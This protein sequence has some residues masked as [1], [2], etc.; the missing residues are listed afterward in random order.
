VT[1]RIWGFD[2]LCP[3][4]I[5]HIPGMRKLPVALFRRT[6]SVL[7]KSPN[8]RHS[9]GHPASGRGTLRPIVTKREAGSDGRVCAPRRSA[10][11]ADGEAVWSWPPDAE[12]KLRKTSFA[13]RRWLQSPAHRGDH[14]VSRKPSRRECRNVRRTLGFELVCFLHCTRGRGCDAHP[15]FPAPS[16]LARAKIMHDSDAIAPR[17]R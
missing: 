2:H 12:V 3:T 13:R 1:L 5:S 9:P 7:P 14:G 6:I 4:S 11:D 10:R 17:E 15:A 8:Q 16:V